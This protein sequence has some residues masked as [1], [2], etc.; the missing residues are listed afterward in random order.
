MLF[1]SNLN[2]YVDECGNT[3]IGVDHFLHKGDLIGDESVINEE[4]SKSF[5]EIDTREIDEDCLC[6]LNLNSNQRKALY[7]FILS[8]GKVVFGLSYMFNLLKKNKYVE[9]SYQFSLYTK[10]NG[11]RIKSLEIRRQEEKELFLKKE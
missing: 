7:S 5:F 2:P 4:Q 11:N 1:F 10:C 9:A 6:S 8:V 3:R